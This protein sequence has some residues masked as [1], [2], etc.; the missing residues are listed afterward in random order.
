EDVGGSD[1]VKGVDMRRNLAIVPVIFLSAAMLACGAIPSIPGL[2]GAGA[3]PT[4]LSEL[5]PDVPKMDGLVLDPNIQVPPWVHVILTIVTKPIL[6]GGTDEGDWIDFTTTKT[7]DDVKAFYTPQLMA[8]NGWDPIDKPT[9][10]FSGADQGVSQVGQVCVFQKS[11][12][13]APP[14]H[15]IGMFLVA[16]QDPTT[17]QTSVFFVRVDAL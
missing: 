13:N 3:Q 15:Y 1:R 6:G 2:P 11:G 17:K 7:P 4:S 14:G 12:A 16:S 9:T 10:C 5:W 8:A